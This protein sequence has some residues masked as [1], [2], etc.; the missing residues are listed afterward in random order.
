MSSP[1]TDEVL[2]PLNGLD[3]I[4]WTDLGHAYGAADD[5]PATLRLLARAGEDPEREERLDHLDASIYHQGGA[6]YSAGAAAVPFLIELAATPGLPMRAAIVELVGRFAALQNEMREPWRSAGHAVACRAALVAGHDTLVALLDDADHSVRTA[7]AA[8]LWEYA[9]WSPRTDDA[10]QALVGRD[11]MESDLALRV[12]LRLDGARAAAEARESDASSAAALAAAVRRL[13]AAPDRNADALRLAC[14]AAD[15]RL[16]P[17]AAS[18]RDLLDAALAPATPHEAYSAWDENGSRLSR[19]LCAMCGD[20]TAAQL[21]VIRA[22][23]GHERVQIRTGALQ[24]AGDAMLRWRSAVPALVPLVA[25]ML[26]E[27]E[28]ENRMRSADLLAAAGAAGAAFDD[29]LAAALDDPHRPTAIRAAWALARHGDVRAVP[30]LVHALNHEEDNGFGPSAH[31]SGRSYWFSQPPLRE[32]LVA[33]AARHAS[34]LAPALRSALARHLE[35]SR[36][37]DSAVI[38]LRVD[39][40]PRFHLLCDALAACGPAAAEAVPELE[41]LLDSTHPQLARPVIE[42]VGPAAAHCVP[43]LERVE[44]V[45][46]EVSSAQ[47]SARRTHNTSPTAQ[48]AP[49]DA[50]PGQ[51]RVPGLGDPWIVALTAARARFAVVG[52][53]AALLRTVDEVLAMTAP[54][55]QG[56]EAGREDSLPKSATAASAARDAAMLASTVAFCLSMLGPGAGS[57]RMRWPEQW[58]RANERW[59]R[60]REAVLAAWAHWRVTGDSGLALQVFQR[61]LEARPGAACGPIELAALRRIAD[62]GPE[63]RTLAPLL[64]ACLDRDER[65]SDGGGWR[66]MALD[67]EVREL[68]SAVLAALPAR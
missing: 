63:A 56:A 41:A 2:A 61:V 68:A 50:S 13:T 43:H 45:A 19:A 60:S 23:I 5:V 25:A 28:P 54:L 7:A 26:T 59:W 39:S 20:D 14:L 51:R 4:P 57:S 35:Q 24:A 8:L 42:A 46:L 31:Y 33:C 40:L 21:N 52:D 12:S 44:R 11:A 38:G 65:I 15:K 34:L 47:M 55:R 36:T 49:A 64:H 66:G 6:V 53:E 22:L 32:A 37:E 10:M 3:D 27:P 16:D 17:T 58:L 18:W 1:A 48:Q 30:T 62:M 29:R 67:E 9:L